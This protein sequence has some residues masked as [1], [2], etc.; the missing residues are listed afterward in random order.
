VFAADYNVMEIIGRTREH[1]LFDQLVKEEK[2]H[3][4]AVY[5]HHRIGKT[6]LIR[7]HFTAFDFYHTGI[8][9]VEM[10]DQL[11]AFHKTAQIFTSKKIDQPTNWFDAFDI[12]KKIIT[13]SRK[14]KKT[15]F[16]DELPWL[17]TPRSNF[18]AALEYFWNGWA[19]NRNDVLLIVCGSATS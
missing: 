15:I 19:S 10:Q 16:L 12:L 18:V 6:F 4:S 2:S 17:D 14:K 1:M 5:G 9:N 7:K 11:A 8:A 3:F 13:N